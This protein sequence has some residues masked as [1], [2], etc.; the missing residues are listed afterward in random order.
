MEFETDQEAVTIVSNTT[1]ATNLTMN[2]QDA[3]L[4]AGLFGLVDSDAELT[5][6][7]NIQA[8]TVYADD[9]DSVLTITA[10]HSLTATTVSSTWSYSSFQ[11]VSSGSISWT[12][13]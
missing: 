1:D 13:R 8:T 5:I 11:N 2:E 3:I 9:T 10:T 7:G 6:D 4:A 12:R